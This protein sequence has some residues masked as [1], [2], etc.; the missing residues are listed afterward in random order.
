MPRLFT[1]IWLPPPVLAEL[2]G[3]LDA[4]PGWPPEGWRAVPASRWHLTLCF[5]GEADPGV[6]AR[7]LDTRLAV[8]DRARAP[9]LRLAGAVS[10]AKVVAAEVC[11]GGPRHDEALAALVAA[12]GADPAGYRPHVTVARTSRRGDRP[13]RGGPLDRFAGCWWRPEE[14][15]LV[16]SEQVSGAPRYTVLHRVPL[17]LDDAR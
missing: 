5:H 2:S 4:D 9:W 12:A 7:R 13:P 8:H 3:V 11:T 10:F 1:A 14:I 16:R 15:C 17:S 6:L